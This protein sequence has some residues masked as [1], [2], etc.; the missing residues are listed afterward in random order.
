MIKK[1]STEPLSTVR[2]EA[3]SD[4]VFAIAITL[5]ILEIKVPHLDLASRETLAAALAGQWASYLAYVVSFLM[6]GIYWV[7]HH[8]IFRFYRATDHF[9]N[10]LNLLFLMMISFLPFPTAIL[11]EYIEVAGAQRIAVMF[12]AFGLLLPTIGF[13]LMWFY[14]S[15]NYRLIDGRLKPE[16]VSGLR[17]KFLYS[18]IVNAAVIGLSYWFYWAGLTVCILITLLYLLPAKEPD[19]SE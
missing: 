13:A 6:I 19:L 1:V 11:S 12:Y 8:Y 10:L 16:F 2:L 14:A 18:M 17:R 7:N 5:L 15:H 9:F 4:G 3:F